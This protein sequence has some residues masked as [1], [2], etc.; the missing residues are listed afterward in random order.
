[1]CGAEPEK[2]ERVLP[3]VNYP[4][5]GSPRP[6]SG[7]GPNAARLRQIPHRWVGGLSSLQK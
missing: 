6:S 3:T 5:F 4:K 7:E 1:M 2:K